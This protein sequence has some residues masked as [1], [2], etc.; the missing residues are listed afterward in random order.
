MAHRTRVLDSPHR[1][2]VA[3]KLDR[4]THEWLTNASRSSNPAT[5]PWKGY[6]DLIRAADE[7]ILL[8]DVQFTK[9]DW[10]SRNRIKTKDGLLWLSI[11]VHT[12]G[13]YEQRILDTTISDPSWAH[14]ALADDSQRLRAHAVLRRLRAAV[15]DAYE[16]PVS[17][18]LSDRQSRRSSMAVCG[19]LGITTPIRWSAEYHPSDGRN[20]RLIDLCV[21]SGAT[22]YLSGPERARLSR[23]ARVQR[24]PAS[25]VHFADYAGYPAYPQPYPPFEHAVS[26]LDLLFCTGP[27]AIDYLKDV[28]AARVIHRRFA[29][30]TGPHDRRADAGAVDRHL[31]VPVGAI[32]RRVSRPLHGRGDATGR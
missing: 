14:N 21:K 18:R 4:L 30:R 1:R 7:F 26:V 8:D 25:A 20:E 5:F 32:S 15:R 16:S 28:G 24:A 2:S 13:R 12:K 31:D 29:R 17:D 19:A 27:R 23:R 3:C 9:R 11:P 22:A 6:F 10:R